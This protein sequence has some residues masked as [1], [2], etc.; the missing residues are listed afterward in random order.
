MDRQL[1]HSESSFKQTGSFRKTTSIR[2]SISRRGMLPS[3]A[4]TVV[5][6]YSST[7]TRPDS[8]SWQSIAE[9]NATRRLCGGDAYS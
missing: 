4:N 9:P 1:R 6:Q 8:T 5:A 3:L 7:H 2:Q